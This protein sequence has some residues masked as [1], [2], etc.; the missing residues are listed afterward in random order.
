IYDDWGDGLEGTAEPGCNTDG[1]YSI[2][3]QWG[4]PY[5]TMQNVAFGSS[6]ASNFCIVLG[7]DE[8][9]NNQVN[10]YPNPSEGLFNVQMKNFTGE[11][12]TVIVTDISGR[13]V[14]NKQVSA[15]TF[16][17]DLSGAAGGSYM[18]TIQSN[19]TKMVKR[20]VVNN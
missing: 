1:T 20:I 10:V 4:Q 14:L 2:T 7:V 5:V 3:D 13:V 6:E 12:H 11:N 8:L 16:Q 9:D 18:M 15:G 17:L 19:T